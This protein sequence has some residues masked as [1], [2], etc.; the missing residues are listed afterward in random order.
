MTENGY[1]MTY[2]GDLGAHVVGELSVVSKNS[3]TQR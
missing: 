2:G 1:N 3:D